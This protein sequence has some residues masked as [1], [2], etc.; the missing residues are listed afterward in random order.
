MP[1]S[2]DVEGVNIIVW[3]NDG[4]EANADVTEMV[5]VNGP[6]AVGPTDCVSVLALAV[7]VYESEIVVLLGAEVELIV[8]EYAVVYV[9]PTI[10][11]S[12]VNVSE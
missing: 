12:Y 10:R 8:N 5:P 6:I 7:N 2:N 4:P 9:L 11:L 1:Q 3:F